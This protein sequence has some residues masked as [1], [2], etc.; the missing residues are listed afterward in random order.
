MG[1]PVEEHLWQSGRLDVDWV[2]IGFNDCGR[3]EL[4]CIIFDNRSIVSKPNLCIKEAL[5]VIK[6]MPEANTREIMTIF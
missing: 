4:N 5:L 1:T 2:Q 3:L 6:K